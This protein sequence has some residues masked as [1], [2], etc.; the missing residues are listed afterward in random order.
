[1]PSATSEQNTVFKADEEGRFNVTIGKHSFMGGPIPCERCGKMM[2]RVVYD[3]EENLRTFNCPDGHGK[4]EL[5]QIR[6]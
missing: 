3:P 1:M 5:I 2:C 6:S 4:S